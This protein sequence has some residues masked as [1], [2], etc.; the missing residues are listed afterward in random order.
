MFKMFVCGDPVCRERHVATNNALWLKDE[1]KNV[2]QCTVFVLCCHVVPAPFVF[3][4]PLLYSN[5][6][7]FTFCSIYE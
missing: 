2:L 7:C 1:G 5:E 6:D 4:A 3:N